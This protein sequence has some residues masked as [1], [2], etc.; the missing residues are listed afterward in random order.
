MSIMDARFGNTVERYYSVRS[1]PFVGGVNLIATLTC[2]R[3]DLRACRF[4]LAAFRHAAC[5]ITTAGP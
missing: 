4:H 5:I 2:L 1:T 3:H